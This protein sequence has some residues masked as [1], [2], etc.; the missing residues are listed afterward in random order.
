MLIIII[1]IRLCPPSLPPYIEEVGIPDIFRQ[2][3]NPGFPDFFSD[4]NIRFH[5]DFKKNKNKQKKKKK[6][7]R[8]DCALCKGTS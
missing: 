3:L 1:I 5:S 6:K 2:K 7:T 8:H 4:I